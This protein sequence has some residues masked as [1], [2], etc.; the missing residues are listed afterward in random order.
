MK[1]TELRELEEG[2]MFVYGN[3]V[4]KSDINDLIFGVIIIYGKR[5]KDGAM[6]FLAGDTIVERIG[7]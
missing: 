5:C 7:Y 3:Q 2:E 4:F 1:K 6:I